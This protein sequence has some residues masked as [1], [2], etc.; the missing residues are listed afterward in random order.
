MVE[1]N[2]SI[3]KVTSFVRRSLPDF[4]IFFIYVFNTKNFLNQLTKLR[5]GA[6]LREYST[7]WSES[8]HDEYTTM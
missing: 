8:F 7:E 2:T 3:K 5:R 4:S 6:T 1:S